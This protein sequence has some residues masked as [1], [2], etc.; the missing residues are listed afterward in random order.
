MTYGH[1]DFIISTV[2]NDNSKGDNFANSDVGLLYVGH[3]IKILVYFFILKSR[4]L[5]LLSLVGQ[6]G[7]AY[8]KACVIFCF[9]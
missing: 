4:D 3:N 8:F 2:N 6:K 5:N 7:M 9:W 1:G